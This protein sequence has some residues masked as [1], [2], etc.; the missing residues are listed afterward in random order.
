[1]EDFVPGSHTVSVKVYLGDEVVVSGDPDLD[2]DGHFVFPVEGLRVA[3]EYR[4]EVELFTDGEANAK[5]GEALLT[6][7]IGDCDD[8]A[9]ADFQA[10]LSKNVTVTVDTSCSDPNSNVRLSGHVDNLDMD[11]YFYR[12]GV[13][14][15]VA[16]ATPMLMV[17]KRG[18]FSGSLGFFSPGTYKAALQYRR[19]LHPERIVPVGMGDPVT[20]TF[21]VP[22]NGCST[23]F[24]G[25]FTLIKD[26]GCVPA[27]QTAMVTLE[28]AFTAPGEHKN[29][30]L[31]ATIAGTKEKAVEVW[32]GSHP[33]LKR[34]M[35]T[36]KNR[37]SAG[38]YVV[39]L[40]ME[41]DSGPFFFYSWVFMD[42]Y[43]YTEMTIPTCA[44]GVGDAETPPGSQDQTAGTTTRADAAPTTS[45]TGLAKTGVSVLPVFLVGAIALASGLALKMRRTREG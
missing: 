10:R 27:G 13:A 38:T 16:G 21:T 41:Y 1:M 7:L 30:R 28:G 11:V 19:L 23:P 20:V 37:L 34:F 33:G 4:S 24:S 18:N 15:A 36:A 35:Y 44:S 22:D 43:M 42:P 25:D 2:E 12:P 40:R 5:V 39:Q 9:D 14:T 26:P 32:R 17:N 45:A 29:H 8:S 6:V 3:G 31:V